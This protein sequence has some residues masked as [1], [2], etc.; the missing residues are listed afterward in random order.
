MARPSS[1]AHSL[2]LGLSLLSLGLNHQMSSAAGT[3]G[4]D[5]LGT[6]HVGSVGLGMALSDFQAKLG[7]GSQPDFMGDKRVGYLLQSA[8]DL[9]TLRIHEYA[10]KGVSTAE[11]LFTERDRGFVISMITLAVSCAT[12]LQFRQAMESKRQPVRELGRTAWS[13]HDANSPNVWGGQTEPICSVW[14]RDA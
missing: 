1:L 10:G 8:S 14:V 3:N 5:A 7:T 12:V 2:F 6:G 9:R 11:L 13:V 4:A